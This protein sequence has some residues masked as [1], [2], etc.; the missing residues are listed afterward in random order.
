MAGHHA[1]LAVKDGVSLQHNQAT[2]WPARDAVSGVTP[3]QS[4]SHIEVELGL[5]WPTQDAMELVMSRVVYETMVLLPAD[6]P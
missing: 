2:L 6:R 5:R 4:N 3:R 1:A